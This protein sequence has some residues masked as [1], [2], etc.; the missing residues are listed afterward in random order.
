MS[1]DIVDFSKYRPCRAATGPDTLAGVPLPQDDMILSDAELQEL[2]SVFP[3]YAQKEAQT[4]RALLNEAM[5]QAYI[6]MHGGPITM[7]QF[8]AYGTEDF[9]NADRAVKARQ[10]RLMVE[11]TGQ[12][13]R[14]YLAAYRGLR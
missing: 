6:E 5:E 3:Q 10:L 7:P 4:R 1:A 13:L 14:E 2:R 11:R 9:R 12:L 8:P